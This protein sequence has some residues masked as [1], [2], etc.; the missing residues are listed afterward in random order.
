MPAARGRQA[1]FVA[2]YHRQG[3]EYSDPTNAYAD[4]LPSSTF[5]A[6]ALRWIRAKYD[7][8]LVYVT[9]SH[10]FGEARRRA[11]FPVLEERETLVAIDH[12][13]PTVVLT[14]LARCDAATFSFGT[15]S[16]WAAFLSNGPVLYDALSL[17]HI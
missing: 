11:L 14:A 8:P 13:D 17:I 10:D 9:S 5:Y 6:A 15:F 2:L 12:Q 4:C 1:T 7:G 3:D 16:W